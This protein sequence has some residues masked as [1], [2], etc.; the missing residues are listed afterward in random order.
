M[1]YFELKQLIKEETYDFLGLDDSLEESEDH[2]SNEFKLK[3]FNDVIENFAN[4]EIFKDIEVTMS[5]DEVG[6]TMDANLV[7]E[8]DT[9]FIY[10][11]DMEKIPVYVHIK[12]VSNPDDDPYD[13]KYDDIDIKIYIGK[14]NKQINVED[15]KREYP[16]LHKKFIQRIV[17]HMLK[18]P[19]QQIF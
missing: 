9:N 3:F 7:L 2:D 6:S 19:D 8:Y 11:T 18:Y 15:F 14:D 16:E 5:K 17:G 13:V 1:K 10:K 12:D 4:P